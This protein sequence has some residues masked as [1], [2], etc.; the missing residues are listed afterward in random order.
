MNSTPQMVRLLTKVAISAALLTTLTASAQ[1]IF[2]ANWSPPG[3]IYQFTPGIQQHSTFY[4]GGLGNPEGLAF[5]S[6]GNLFVAGSSDDE[7]D[8]ISGG[9]ESAFASVN[10]PVGL[11]FDGSGNLFVTSD[12]KGD[13][14]EVSASAGHAVTT[15]TTGLN[16]P[17]GIAFDQSGDL[18]VSVYNSSMIYEYKNIG[19]TLSTSASV[20][21]QGLYKVN[22]LAFDAAGNLYAAYNGL[23]GEVEKITPQGNMSLYA[24]G[25]N[26]NDGL[27]FDNAGDLYVCNNGGVT[28][29]APGGG[30]GTVIETG[31]GNPT[32]IAIQGITL[33]TARV[34]P[35][36]STLS[37]K[38]LAILLLL[39]IILAIWIFDLTRQ[40]Q[41]S[42]PV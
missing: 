4:S 40:K 33:G 6:S 39:L 13:I 20:F 22:G 34:L 36:S 41:Q 37:W 35:V 42:H 15:F 8:E 10:H 32:G 7:I 23:N 16:L 5:D 28:E 11:A 2:V 27:A 26:G 38:I 18:F 9:T 19:G 30:T 3:A 14:Y 17:A 25:L 1:R 21:A 29:F 31:L 12:S 24:T